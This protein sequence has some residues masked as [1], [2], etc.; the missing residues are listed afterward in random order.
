MILRSSNDVDTKAMYHDTDTDM[1]LSPHIFFQV[2]STFT[3]CK[4]QAT[5]FELILK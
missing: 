5:D 2:T 1:I 3:M 4:Y